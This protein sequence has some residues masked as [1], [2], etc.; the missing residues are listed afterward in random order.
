MG[1][2]RGVDDVP[3]VGWDSEE[4]TYREED[5]T[6]PVPCDRG[7][8]PEL[9]IRGTATVPANRGTV[10]FMGLQILDPTLGVQRTNNSEEKVFDRDKGFA[11]YVTVAQLDESIHVVYDKLVS[12]QNDMERRRELDI[13]EAAVLERQRSAY[14]SRQR[15]SEEK[16]MTVLDSINFS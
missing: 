16:V 10:P 8:T 2:L 5:D 15:R 6:T 9:G 12:Y 13:R 14:V 7:T 11:A 4:K 3:P 1:N